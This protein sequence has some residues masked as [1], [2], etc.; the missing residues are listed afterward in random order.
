LPK[1]PFALERK[2]PK[3]VATRTQSTAINNF[4][5]KDDGFGALMEQKK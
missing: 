4:P 5:T 2:K 1:S 3:T